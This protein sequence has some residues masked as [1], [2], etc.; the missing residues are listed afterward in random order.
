VPPPLALAPIDVQGAT[1]NADGSITLPEGTTQLRLDYAALSYT[2]PERVAFRYRLEGVDDDWRDA[3][4]RR[5]AYY[6]GL[7]PGDYRFR[8]VAFNEDG[9]PSRGEASVRFTIRPT[10]VQTRWFL[11]TCAV[12]ALGLLAS[13]YLWRTR[14]LAR[15]YADR[16]QERL[17]ERERIARA[18]HDTLL[19][20]MQGLILRFHSVVKRLPPDSPVRRGMAE[21]LED[22]DAV[23]SEGRNEVL[24][25]RTSPD[26]DADLAQ[27]LSRF[28]RSLQENFGPRFQLVVT[29]EA[30][31]IHAFAWQ[32]IYVIGREA[33]FN[34]YQHALADHIEAEI[35]YDRDQ[36]CLFVRDDGAGIEGDVRRDGRREG[37]WGLAGMRERAQTL[38]GSL[39]LWSR[40]HK[41]TEVVLRVPADRVYTAPARLDLRQW[42]RALLGR[43]GKLGA[44]GSA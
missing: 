41:G 11:L 5:S 13:L 39:D 38:H 33:L 35:V 2:K 16:L 25:L 21:I 8:V 31:A 19:Q 27:A 3:G 36:L 34:A 23:M 20:S 12:A 24:N 32:E 43:S 15:R 1:R 10:F 14:Q 44:P 30:R 22:A 7:G 29:G 4:T 9:V 40:P 26:E 42:L 37:H 18:L 17:A 28:G 6:T